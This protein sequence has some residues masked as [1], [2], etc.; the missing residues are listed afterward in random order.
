MIGC[1]TGAIH[2]ERSSGIV[3][4]DDRTCIGCGTCANNCPYQAIRMVEVRDEHG[5]LQVDSASGSPILRATKCDLCLGQRTG[6]ACAYACPH[7]ALERVDLTS[8]AG[9]DRLLGR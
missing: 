9:P 5:A 8:L 6:P 1:P 3:A 4:I 7:D 2:R